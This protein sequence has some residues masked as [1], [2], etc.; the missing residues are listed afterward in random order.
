[1]VLNRR[2]KVLSVSDGRWFFFARLCRKGTGFSKRLMP[3]G[4]F[5]SCA[6][7]KENK[8]VAGNAISRSYLLSE[9]KIAHS[10]GG[11]LCPDFSQS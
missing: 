5:L 4:H 10:R 2:F 3:S 8:E 9:R 1:M 11:S 7:K 6:T